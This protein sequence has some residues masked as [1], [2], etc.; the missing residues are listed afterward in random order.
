MAAHESTINVARGHSSLGRPLLWSSFDSG[1]NNVFFDVRNVDSNK[2][3]ILLAGH[4]TLANS[5]WIG[6]SDSRASHTSMAYPFRMSPSNVR[7]MNIKTT[8]VGDAHARS[9]FKSTISA[10][11]T[12]GASALASEVW[13]IF[14][15]G[16]FEV[17]RFKDSD[18]YIN[19]CRGV[20]TAG[21][22]SHSSDEQ[23]V[24]AIILP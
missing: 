14:A 12:A 23:Q 17:N 11:A 18:G 19:I 10:P 20:Q 2:M 22:A 8:V 4:S 16:P 6:T 9:K 13:G 24:C 5:I 15:L 21:A 7:R 1:A 3:I